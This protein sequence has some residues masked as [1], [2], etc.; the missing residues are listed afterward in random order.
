M[1]TIRSILGLV[2]KENLHL[3]QMDVNIAFHHGDLDEKI[4]MK[5]PEGFEVKGKEKLVCKLKKSLYGLKQAPR[6][7]Y[8]KFD[9]FMKKAEFSR[10]EADDR[11][12]FA[13]AKTFIFFRLAS[14]KSGRIHRDR[15]ENLFTKYESNN[16]VVNSEQVN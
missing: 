16:G 15:F 7:W 2:A 9:S 10:C 12:R 13:C 14:G 8:K 6:Q 5:Q 11:C 1:V 3:Q 4:Y